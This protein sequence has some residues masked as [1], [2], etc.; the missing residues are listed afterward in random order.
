MRSRKRNVQEAQPDTPRICLCGA[1][2]E[3]SGDLCRKCRGRLR[4]LRRTN[5]K[6]RDQWR[7]FNWSNF[8]FNEVVSAS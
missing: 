5:G 8:F 4:R 1:Q 3:G 7:E 2:V 6:R